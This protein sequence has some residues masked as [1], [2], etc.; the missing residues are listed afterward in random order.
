MKIFTKICFFV[1]VLTSFLG[2]LPQKGKIFIIKQWHLS[3]KVKTN[4]IEESKKLPQFSNQQQIYDYLAENIKEKKIQ[5]VLTEGCEGEI[6]DKFGEDFYGWKMNDLKKLI[7]EPYYSEVL[8]HIGMKIKAAFDGDVN[9]YCGD[10]LDL[11]RNHQLVMSEIRGHLGFFLRLKQ[12]Q[13]EN[14]T[15]EFQ[16]YAKRLLGDNNSEDPIVYSKNKIKENFELFKRYIEQRNN[17]FIK[18]I[19][20]HENDNQAI[21]IGGLHVK[22]LEKKLTEQGF[23]VQV[24]T[25]K[26]YPNEDQELLKKI[27]SYIN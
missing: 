4:D 13:S 10:N 27:E 3:P 5:T 1:F 12:F 19:I 22:D 17:Y 20:G 8:G 23:E 6:N 18:N 15:N 2:C 14:K 24:I 26:G 9:V 16:E 11:V 21:V 7:H 25:P